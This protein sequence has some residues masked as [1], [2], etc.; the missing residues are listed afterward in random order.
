MVAKYVYTYDLMSNTKYEECLGSAPM[1]LG[2][3]LRRK[4]RRSQSGRP[5]R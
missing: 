4:P 5:M 2:E 1:G 3:L